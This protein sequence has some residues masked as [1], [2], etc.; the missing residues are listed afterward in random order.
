MTGRRLLYL[1]CL[2]TAVLFYIFDT[3]YFSFILLMVGVAFLPLELLISLPGLLAARMQLEARPG[4]ATG[5]TPFTLRITGRAM[6]GL[7]SFKATLRCKNLFDGSGFKKKLHLPMGTAHTIAVEEYGTPCGALRFW[8]H[9]PRVLDIAG[10]LAFPLHAPSPVMALARPAPPEKPPV[11]P[12]AALDQS[13]LPDHSSGRPGPGA[14]REFTDIREYR[15]GDPLRDI[16]WK[17]TAKFDKLMVREGSFSNLASPQLCFDFY[18]EPE[19][20]ARTLARLEGLSRSLWEIERL[21]GVHWLDA[22]GTLCSRFILGK[23][24]FDAL[25]WSLLETPLPAEGKPILESPPALPGPMLRVL[26]QA[27]E[28]YEEG[29][30]KEVVR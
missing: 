1:G 17:L 6:R 28:L 4:E 29:H 25:L 12:E 21:H 23:S 8:L 26:P 20:V 30:L 2:C 3:G 24:D 27:T 14:M 19:T 5:G 16:H 9:R 22:E 7:C 11:M 13:A 15:E 18:G 10:L